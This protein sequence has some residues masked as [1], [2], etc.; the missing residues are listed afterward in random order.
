VGTYFYNSCK[1]LVFLLL[2]EFQDAYSLV[3]GY[4]YKAYNN[5]TSALVYAVEPEYCSGASWS[6]NVLDTTAVTM[7]GLL[8]AVAVTGRATGAQ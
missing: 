4:L 5:V 3:A 2:F 6:V 1:I 8:T 7:Y